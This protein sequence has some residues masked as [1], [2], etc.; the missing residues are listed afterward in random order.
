MAPEFRPQ[1]PYPTHRT[2]CQCLLWL[3]LLALVGS[4]PLAVRASAQAN[5]K[6]VWSKPYNIGNVPV[7]FIVAPSNEDTLHSQVFW[8]RDRVS[9]GLLK[10]G[11]PS[12]GTDT[13]SRIFPNSPGGSY[14]A[15]TLASPS[16]N[17]FCGSHTRLADGRISVA[18]GTAVNA[19][20]V[21]IRNNSILD[22]ATRQYVTGDTLVMAQRR[23]YPTA[24]TLRD[25]KI[26]IHSGSEYFHVHLFGGSDTSGF[27]PDSLVRLAVT[28]SGMW[29]GDVTDPTS[30]NRPATRDL[31][32]MVP[33]SVYS[34]TEYFGGRSASGTPLNDLFFAQRDGGVNDVDYAY[35]WTPITPQGDPHSSPGTPAARYL[36]AATHL[37]GGELVV[38]GGTSLSSIFSDLWVLRRT[39]DA[40]SFTYTWYRAHQ[41]GSTPT[42]RCGA[43]LMRQDG[44]SPDTLLLFGGAGGADALPTDSTVY[45]VTV[46]YDSLLDQYDATPST[47]PK[48]LR[49]RSCRRGRSQARYF[50]PPGCCIRTGVTVPTSSAATTVPITGSQETR[51]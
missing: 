12:P 11:I 41:S 25:G 18:G 47:R 24:T 4:G 26:L 39:V 28:D 38:F 34:A 31:H 10:W 46:A 16:Y 21:G 1:E 48:E 44:V 35:S 19:F 8:W 37:N 2:H 27:R 33:N 6:G 51:C 5:V 42:A 13:V 3:L 9:H 50:R 43:T 49:W 29:D 17:H 7:H 22:P 40:P 32:S 14:S 36:A 15:D 20:E 45:A 30:G 23:W